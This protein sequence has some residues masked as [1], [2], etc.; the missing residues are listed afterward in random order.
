[1]EKKYSIEEFI[2]IIKRLRAED[3][4]PWD[5]VQTHDTLRSCM[6]EEAAELLASIRI[7]NQTGNA[8]N[9]EEELGDI[10]LQVVMHSVIADEEGLFTFEDVVDEETKKMIYRHPHVFGSDTV[11]SSSEQLEKWEELKKKEKEGKAWITTPLRDI[12]PELPALTRAAKTIRKREQIYH[13]DNA[14]EENIEILQDNLN[15]LQQL[16]DSNDTAMYENTLGKMLLAISSIA[17]KKRI[18]PEQLLGDEIDKIVE[19]YETKA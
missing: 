6:M 19:K 18:S 14:L 17:A 2:E 7:Y 4:C 5:K 12:P 11:N 13:V 9:M 16:Q 3:G 10:L 8:E 15:I 1:M